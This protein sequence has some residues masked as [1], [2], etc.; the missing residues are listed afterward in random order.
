MARWLLMA[1][2]TATTGDELATDAGFIARCSAAANRG[3]PSR[4]TLGRG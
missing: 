1:A 4:S 2:A 3:V